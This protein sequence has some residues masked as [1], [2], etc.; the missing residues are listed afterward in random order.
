MKSLFLA[1]F[2]AALSLSSCSSAFYQVYNTEAP[3]M[4]EKENSLVYENDDCKL[5]YNLWAENGNSG[6][7][8]HNKTK[9]DLFIILPQTFFIKNGVAFDYYKNR[10]FRNTESSLTSSR[11]SFSG[12]ANP[13]G[14]WYTTKPSN[15]VS[16]SKGISATVVRKENPI[17]CIPANSS[18]LICEYSISSNLIRNCEKKQAYPKRKS[19]PI[20]FTKE[21]TPLI[22]KNRIAYSFDKNG[23]DLKFIE[24]EFWVSELTNYSKKSAGANEK[25]KDCDY[26]VPVSQYVFKIASPNKFYNSYRGNT[27][28]GNSSNKGKLIY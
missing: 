11:S 22:F 24:N 12:I 26:D 28:F 8:V 23:N 16:N 25:M 10:E 13:W 15:V 18:K 21:D 9:N 4:I 1:A 27:S 2:V 19:V 14:A 6:F 17:V 7:V 20:T 5:M 3:G